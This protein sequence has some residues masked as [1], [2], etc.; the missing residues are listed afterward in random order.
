MDASISLRSNI[1][2][3]DPERLIRVFRH[4]Q[5]FDVGFSLELADLIEASTNLITRDLVESPSANRAFRAILQ[6]PGQVYPI[7]SKM[8][9]LGVLGR[10]LPEFG[11]LTCL[12]QH[13]HYHRYTRRHPY[14]GHHPGVGPGQP[15][16]PPGN[17]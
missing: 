15:H 6:S 2:E 13:E 14:P 5:Q 17:G 7:L 8:H 1:F 12:V 3:E 16:R 4:R 11:E 9:Q 10:F